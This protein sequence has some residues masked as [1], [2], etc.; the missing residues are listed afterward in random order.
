VGPAELGG[1]ALISAGLV[2][3][4][5]RVLRWPRRAPAGP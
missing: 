5:G 4:G 2:T 3:I 1:M